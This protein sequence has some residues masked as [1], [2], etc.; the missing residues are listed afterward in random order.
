LR[1]S[2]SFPKE[3]EV[4]FAPLTFLQPTGR[5]QVLKLGGITVTIVE[6]TPTTS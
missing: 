4:L 3:S 6:V 2:P 1:T 5:S